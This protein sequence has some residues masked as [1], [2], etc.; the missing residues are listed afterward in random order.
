[1]TKQQLGAYLKGIREQKGYSKN[2]MKIS[3]GFSNTTQI[4]DI[5]Q[6]RSNYTIEVLLKYCNFLGIDEEEFKEN[7]VPIA[8]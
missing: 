4:D 7:I 1:M 2:G 5:E 8:D 3:A 6:G